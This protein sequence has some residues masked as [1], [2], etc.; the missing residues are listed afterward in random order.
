M[1]AKC[2][3]LT[4]YNSDRCI[5][6]FYSYNN[7]HSHLCVRSCIYIARAGARRYAVKSMWWEAKDD[8]ALA[9]RRHPGHLAPQLRESRWVLRF[10]LWPEA[11]E[12]EERLTHCRIRPTAHR[13][14]ARKSDPQSS[15]SEGEPPVTIT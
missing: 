9:G 8:F 3:A 13:N 1:T 5:D 6:S 11:L 7:S 12:T 15:Q 10:L 4:D 2:A 14:A